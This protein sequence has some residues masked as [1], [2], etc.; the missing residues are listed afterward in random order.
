[1]VAPWVS[2]PQILGLEETSVEPEIVLAET[3]Q[4]HFIL[5]EGAG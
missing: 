1:M 3:K 4:H 5:P 2:E